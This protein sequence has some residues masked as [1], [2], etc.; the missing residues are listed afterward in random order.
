MN[1]QCTMD[2]VRL[3]VSWTASGKGLG[4]DLSPVL[5]LVRLPLYS[6]ELTFRVFHHCFGNQKLTTRRKDSKM[7]T[8]KNKKQLVWGKDN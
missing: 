8:N 2:K 6:A 4:S 5:V 7:A 1:Q 3:I